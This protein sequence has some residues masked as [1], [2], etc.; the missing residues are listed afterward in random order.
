MTCGY[1]E[2]TY[3]TAENET[4]TAMMVV[5][6]EGNSLNKA[7]LGKIT[8]ITAISAGPPCAMGE[9]AT[10]LAHMNTPNVARDFDLVRNLTGYN[11]LNYWGYSYGSVLG[12]TYAQMFPERVGRMVIDG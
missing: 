6:K 7:Q 10:Y 4:S 11:V 3:A 12:T 9:N 5:A 2:T 1:D 8:E